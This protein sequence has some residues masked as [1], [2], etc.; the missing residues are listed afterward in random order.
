MLVCFDVNYI[1]FQVHL[2]NVRV[3]ESI[4]IEELS[5]KT[6]GCS[7][8][9]LA[10]IVNDGALLAVRNGHNNVCM[11]HLI[12]AIERNIKSRSYYKSSISSFP[13]LFEIANR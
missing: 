8:A 13:D 3:G 7:G 12:E 5:A 4:I 11:S 9:D 1:D 10:N 6:E 2:Q